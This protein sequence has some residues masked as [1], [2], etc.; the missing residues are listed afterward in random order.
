MTAATA[1]RRTASARL[2]VGLLLAIGLWLITG[3]MAEVIAHEGTGTLTV[4][5]VQPAG[6]DSFRYVVKLVWAD[7]HPVT[8]ATVTVIAEGPGPKVGP[9]TMTAAGSDGL[10]EA[11]MV[12]PTPGEWTVRFTSVTPTATVSQT[13]S[14][15]GTESTAVG[16]T[17]MGSTAP[18][19]AAPATAA[20]T[21]A[22]PPPATAGSDLDPTGSSSRAIWI[23]LGLLGLGGA[24]AAGFVARRNRAQ[25]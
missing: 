7:G 2:G 8:D 15:T 10:Y 22:V 17:A 3:L 9:V 19:T 25:G 11:L 6:V 18:T 5:A 13:Q 24:A 23:V 20:P 1:V 14:I 16:S 21:T 12:F 4:E